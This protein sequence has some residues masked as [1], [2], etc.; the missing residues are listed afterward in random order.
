MIWSWSNFKRAAEINKTPSMT[1]RSLLNIYAQPLP[2]TASN[3]NCKV[4]KMTRLSWQIPFWLWVRSYPECDSSGQK[5]WCLHIVQATPCRIPCAF[6]AIKTQG[7]ISSFTEGFPLV[8]SH[9][10]FLTHRT[11]PEC[12]WSRRYDLHGPALGRMIDWK[13]FQHIWKASC[14]NIIHFTSEMSP[15]CSICLRV[16][17]TAILWKTLPRKK[18][19]LEKNMNWKHQIEVQRHSGHRRLSNVTSAIIYFLQ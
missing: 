2:R 8:R 9:G 7:R 12:S 17:Q 18:D 1:D 3:T 13:V 6:S 14:N 11:N 10:M 4:S 5:V 16:V 19:Y 15:P